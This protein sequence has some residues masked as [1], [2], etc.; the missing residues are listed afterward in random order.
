MLRK[1]RVWPPLSVDGQ[2]MPDHRLDAEAV[3]DRAEV[4]VVVETGHQPF[5]GSRLLGL[6]PVDH[7]LVEVRGPQAPDPA[8]EVDV[9]RVVD[10]RQ[11]VERARHLRERQRVAPPLVL[12]LD[13]PLLDVDVG[14]A[15]LAH[16][17]ELHEVAVGHQLADGEEQ[18]QRAD[19]VR[20]LGLDRVAAGAHRERR[21][22]LLAVVDDRLRTGVGEDAVE[23]LRVLDGADE[24]TDL[25]P[26]HVAPGVDAIVERGDRG[27]RVR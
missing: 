7:A 5:I 27:Q 8:G 12:D 4:L 16:R 20:V 14:R 10:L 13:E 18:V 21:R 19:H 6:D 17:A 15:V 23:E 26:R 11:V 2:R 22:G 24:G 9:V 3:E 25:V 1:P